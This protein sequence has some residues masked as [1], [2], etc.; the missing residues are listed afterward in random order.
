MSMLRLKQSRVLLL[1]SS[2]AY[3]MMQDVIG[4]TQTDVDGWDRIHSKPVQQIPVEQ[5][6]LTPE[7]FTDLDTVKVVSTYRVADHFAGIAYYDKATNMVCHVV[8][9]AT[10][11]DP[12]AIDCTPYKAPKK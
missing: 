6:G 12:K 11:L 8:T 4:A 7:E 2:V 9:N 3:F 1:V 10:L 5:Q